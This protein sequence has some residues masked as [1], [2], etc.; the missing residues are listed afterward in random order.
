MQPLPSYREFLRDLQTEFEKVAAD[1]GDLYT[2][3]YQDALD[4]MEQV[5]EHNVPEHMTYA[6][7]CGCIVEMIIG[8]EI[9]I[10]ALNERRGYETSKYNSLH[11]FLNDTK[12][13]I[14]HVLTS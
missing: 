1:S 13:E 6:F 11:R 14:I 8:I 4:R 10:K 12:L 5:M 9:T 3:E 2:Q 7:T